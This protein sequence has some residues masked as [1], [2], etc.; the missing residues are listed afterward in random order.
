MKAL[1]LI[2]ILLT[3]G[4]A[5]AQT[6][7]VTSQ[8]RNPEH[9]PAT[10]VRVAAMEAR[11]SNGGRTAS[12]VLVSIAQTDSAGRYRLDTIPAGRY[13]ITAGLVDFPTYH[14]GVTAAAGATIL[15][16]SSGAI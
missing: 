5:Q 8:M 16:V 11:D 6:G 1:L 12:P 15:T 14:P 13:Y 7:V 9:S 2:G 4:I 3:Q 10:G